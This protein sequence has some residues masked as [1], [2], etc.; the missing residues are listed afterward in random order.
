[1]SDA[2]A[3]LE[4]RLA[5]ITDLERIS[6]VLL[7]GSADDDAARP[8][9]ITAPSIF[10]ASAPRPRAA[11]RPRDGSPARRASATRGVAGARLRRRG[12]HPRRPATDE[13]SCR[14]PTELRAEMT[15]AAAEARP[16]WVKARAESNFELF[17]PALERTFELRR[18]YV[19]CFDDVDEPY[20]ILLDDFEPE[21]TTAEVRE[22]F[23]ELKAELVPL[24]AE[25]RDHEVDDSFLTR[26]LSRRPTGASLQGG[27]RA[28][29]LPARHVA[30]RPDG[31]SVRV[32]RGRR[33]HPHH[34]PLRPG[35]R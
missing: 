1:M 26:D 30:P 18:R 16:V 5:K 25:L 11:D 3:Q 9:P 19:D 32:G 22:I 28:V 14:V 7:V 20:D 21:T 15:R 34:D 6:R 4:N 10:D 8:A 29:R 17:L 13:K 31:A 23:A 2:L 27:R 24:I 33:R 12:S 35:R